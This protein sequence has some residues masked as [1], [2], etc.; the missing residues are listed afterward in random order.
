[1]SRIRGDSESERKAGEQVQFCEACENSSG[2]TD[3]PYRKESAEIVLRN[4]LRKVKLL[5]EARQL[6]AA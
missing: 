5:R 6:R 1:M 4:Y 2:E 3:F